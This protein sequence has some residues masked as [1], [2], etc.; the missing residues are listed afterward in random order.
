MR[1]RRWLVIVF[2]I[3]AGLRVGWVS[4]RFRGERAATVEYPDERGYCLVA[5]SLAGGHGLVDEFGFRATYMPAYPAF[6]ALFDG[7]PRSLFW[8]RIAQALLGAWVAPATFLLA[9]QWVRLAGGAFRDRVTRGDPSARAEA[10]GSSSGLNRT[11]LVGNGRIAVVAGLAAAFDPFLIFFSGL[12]LTE[13]LFAA[14]LVTAWVFVLATCPA[15][16]QLE[17]RHG[18]CA[19][20]VLGAGVMLWVCVLLRPSAVILVVAVPVMV[21]AWGRFD[22]AALAA[23]AAMVGI[24]IVGLMP[25]AARNRVVTGEWRW[26]TTRGG[27]SL[28][29]GLRAGATGASDLAHTKTLP[30]VAGLSE[31]EWDRY[32]RSQAWSAAREDPIRVVRLG[33]RKFLRTWSLVPN[34]SSYRRGPAAVVSAAW[35]L[36][37]LLSAAIG[38]WPH[39]RAVRSWVTLLLPV[40]AFTLLHM[41]FVGSV[42]YR[43]PVMPMVMVLSA[44]GM[45]AVRVR[46]GEIRAGAGS[47]IGA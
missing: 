19:R 16:G 47:K 7:L 5:R 26:L 32:F 14:A 23:G 40:V 9:R 38:W 34:V 20:D 35:M 18:F 8:A 10:R 42:R 4:V 11:R 41:V 1:E 6:V 46:L 33:G 25:W 24:V 3:A 13:T 39:R 43:V 17:A 12:L 44:A 36:A 22:R 29:D 30:A 2:V 21:A 15:G 31:I 45:S 27:I 37:V 28:Y